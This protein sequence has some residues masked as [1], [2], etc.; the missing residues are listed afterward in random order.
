MVSSFLFD[1]CDLHV[2]RVWDLIAEFEEESLTNDLSD[3]QLHRLI[4]IVVWIV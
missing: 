2:A 4:S 3:T 1:L